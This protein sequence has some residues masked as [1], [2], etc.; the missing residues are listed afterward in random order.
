VYS[1]LRVINNVEEGCVFPYPLNADKAT[2]HTWFSEK[3]VPAWLMG[4]MAA[5]DTL[6]VNQYVTDMGFKLATNIFMLEEVEQ[7]N[8]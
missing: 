6:D 7:D 5:V 2:H 4:K 1:G 3:D 8:A